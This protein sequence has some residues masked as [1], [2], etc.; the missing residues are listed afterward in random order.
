METPAALGDWGA[1]QGHMGL[2]DDGWGTKEEHVVCGQL[3]CESQSLFLSKHG[4]SL[5]L[6]TGISG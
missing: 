4:D 6:E 5:S 2:C 1:A 3:G